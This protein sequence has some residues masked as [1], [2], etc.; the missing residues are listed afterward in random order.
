MG[1]EVGARLAGR[2]RG[3]VTQKVT[4]YSQNFTVGATPLQKAVCEDSRNRYRT[5]GRSL[6]ATRG[7]GASVSLLS[8]SARSGARSCVTFARA[9]LSGNLVQRPWTRRTRR[10]GRR[11]RREQSASA[12]EAV[13]GKPGPMFSSRSVFW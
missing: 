9:F 1:F 4:Q 12:C 6:L 11:T 2:G 8:S 7:G 5:G 13:G 3:M 10:G